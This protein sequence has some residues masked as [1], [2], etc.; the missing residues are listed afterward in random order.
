MKS[1]E[2]T[3]IAG[4]VVAGVIVIAALAFFLYSD[5]DGPADIDPSTGTAAGAGEGASLNADIETGD[6]SGAGGDDLEKVA[7]PASG[8]AG[9][10]QPARRM[11]KGTG[12]IKGRVLAE[13][14]GALT[15]AEVQFKIG[16]RETSF[17]GGWIDI[18]SDEV[19]TEEMVSVKT[20]PDGRFILPDLP[21]AK[22]ARLDIV[23]ADYVDQSL[24]LGE[25][26]GDAKDVGDIVLELGGRIA[27]FVG[28]TGGAPIEGAV[29]R[30]IQSET[31]VEEGG[32]MFVIGGGDGPPGG[33]RAK[34]G[35]DGRYEVTGVPAGQ[36]TVTVRHEHHPTAIQR[37]VRLEKGEL[38][39]NVDFSLEPGLA[40]SGKVTDADGEPI[41]GIR[42]GTS[43]STTLDLNEFTQVGSTF[44]TV[45]TG[46]DGTYTL[47]GL[48]E[49]EYVV[50]ASGGIFLPDTREGVKAGSAGVDFALAEGGTV[51]GRLINV[52]TGK[53]VEDFRLAVKSDLLSNRFTG[54]ILKGERAA[55]IIGDD[56]PAAG[57]Y[58]VMGLGAKSLDIEIT[59]EGYAKASF[60]DLAAA[61]G[62]K[63]VRDFELTPESR[64]S[65]IVLSPE[66]DPVA[67]ARLELTPG[68]PAPANASGGTMVVRKSYRM[69]DES[70]EEEVLLDDSETITA[71]SG[72]DGRF[73]FKNVPEDMYR[74]EA[75]HD[76]YAGPDPIAVEAKEGEHTSD[77]E[78]LM[79]PGGGIAGTVYGK[80]GQ[81]MSGGKVCLRQQGND[82]F[83]NET[84]TSDIDGK[85]EFR[86]LRPGTYFVSLTR[87]TSGSIM[88]AIISDQQEPSE[89]EQVV[90]VVEGE[91]VELDLFDLPGCTVAGYV[92]EADKPVEGIPV[93]LYPAKGMALMASKSV[94]TDDEGAYLMEDV[95]PGDYRVTLD[96]GGL[97]EPIEEQITAPVG[98]RVDQDF[99]LPSGRVSGRVTDASTGLGIG[100]VQVTLKVPEPETP[101]EE[102]TVRASAMFV[103]IGSM[104]DGGG[105]TGG[106]TSFT[107]GGT[108]GKVKTDDEGYYTIKYLKEGTYRLEAE[109]GSH[110][111]GTLE[112][113]TV[114]EGKETE[115]VDIV[116]ARGS[117]I[118][119][120]VVDTVTGDAV[121]RCPVMVEELDEKGQPRE[122]ST[123][124]TISGEDGS[125]SMEG[126]EAGR[127]RIRSL[128]P[129]YAGQIDIEVKPGETLKDVKL[130]VTT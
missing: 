57:A 54:M 106:M 28:T 32:G 12:R 55:A 14:A 11:A 89:G 69:R 23:H 20:G 114:R 121:S 4:A 27:G 122:G 1:R 35:K 90:T 84:A 58:C 127:Y 34:T 36:V 50:K 31:V 16:N 61:A 103:S 109:G 119:G 110:I 5:S 75:S 29:V 66:G 87:K 82:P 113:V 91:T 116:L 13:Q 105:E 42:V 3:T 88:M 98:G 24:S 64:I 43:H 124:A 100:G 125:F 15:G 2:K 70:G 117:V 19:G 78:V 68:P 102:R 26:R 46:V 96:L 37:K 73:V 17:L 56:G 25:Y 81:P 51:C 7:V 59:A 49:G 53:P 40:I 65:G 107:F 33:I 115:G 39:P 129:D 79:L 76:D 72:V 52:R 101:G 74:L 104:D 6:G 62:E 120:V 126:F 63:V 41:E 47:H 9:G 123:S 38:V 99:S 21:A 111:K 83:S 86:G 112:P 30:A 48:S 128:R 130:E 10:D 18:P 93:H 22:K 60:D 118:S 67:G 94:R 95:R 44:K 97:P 71:K 77:V 45:R 85:Y 92:T 80:D 8:S 108:G